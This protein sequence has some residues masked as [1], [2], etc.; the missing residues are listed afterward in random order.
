MFQTLLEIAPGAPSTKLV[1]QKRK[2]IGE[3]RVFCLEKLIDVGASE[4]ISIAI[5]VDTEISAK[6]TFKKQMAGTVKSFFKC[7]DSLN[8]P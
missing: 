7:C 3:F 5:E 6:A 1:G 4:V 8:K 2:K